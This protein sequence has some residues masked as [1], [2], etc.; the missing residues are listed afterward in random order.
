[1]ST[2][3]AATIAAK[4]HLSLVRVL[5]R[6]FREHHPDIPFFVL[7]ADE[8]DGHFDPSA[9]PFQLLHLRDL[10][11]PDLSRFCFHYRQQEL[12][13]AATPY[14]LA[15]LLERG[16]D[17]ACFLKQES[18]VLNDLGP[19]LER[20]SSHSISLTPH[21]LK[22]LIGDDRHERELT[23]LQSGVYNVGF[24]G[25]TKT[26]TT[27]KFLHWW[28]DRLYQYCRHDIARGMHYEQRWLDLVPGFF[29]DVYIVRDP[30]FN[31][32][33]WNLPERSIGG[34]GYHLTAEGET[35]RFFRFSG[36]D[37][38][39]PSAVTRY[40]SR[41]QTANLGP[42]AI[43]FTRYLE[44]LEAAGYHETKTWPYA[45]DYFDNAVPIPDVAR[46]LYRSLEDDAVRFGDPFRTIDSESYFDWLKQPEEA[47]SGPSQSLRPLWQAILNGGQTCERPTRIRTV[48]IAKVSGDGSRI[49]GQQNMEF[50]GIS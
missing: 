43:V 26:E 14:L 44:L 39:N 50:R 24:L 5:A 47:G 13:Y 4:R 41:L 6:S 23:I 35:C 37:P 25:V 46:E 11:I 15:H 9:E 16:F 45:F 27:R 18:L 12:T 36:F 1:M 40:S 7:L 8:I 22:P 21:L 19:V 49:R 48:S 34:S 28:Q 31:I 33:H 10:A 2:L 42:A 30:G 38:E 20:L 3:A 32:G 29:E 17:S